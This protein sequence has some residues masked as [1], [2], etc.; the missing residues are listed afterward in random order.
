M[1]EEICRA[2]A[3][4]RVMH[5]TY[6]GHRRLIE[7]FCYGVSSTGKRALRAYQTWSDGPDLFAEGWR[8]FAEEKMSNTVVTEDVFDEAL[9]RHYR[10]EDRQFI[11]ILCAV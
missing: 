9:R 5:I 1:R 11:S 8:L 6:D 3:A 10:R 7:P 4:R 2:I